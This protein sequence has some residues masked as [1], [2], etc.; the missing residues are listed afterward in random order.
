MKKFLVI[1]FI[2][3]FFNCGNL[4]RDNPLDPKNPDSSVNRAILVELFVNDSTG[5]EFCNY[6]LD[7]IER[8]SQRE[9]NLYVLEYHLTNRTNNWNDLY[10]LD[11]FNQR[12]YEYVPTSSQRGIPDA[13]FN[14][15]VKRIQGASKE[16]IDRRYAEVAEELMGQ[17][18]YFSIAA[19]KNISN[20]IITLNVVV[21]RYGSLTENNIDLNVVLYENL[22]SPRH[23]FVVRKIF[24]KQ[25]IH[26]ISPGEAKSFNFYS[27]LP[28]VE[29]V[30]NLFALVFLQDRKRSTKEVYQVAE[31]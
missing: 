28:Q 2:L 13:L 24:Q 8:L 27:Q 21:A 25:T 14:G 23:Y 6:A 4:D 26:S 9:E 1:L 30:A 29:N 18:G 20:N 7:A 16:Q 15:M 19:K 12:Y 10:A 17:R 5:F 22:S 31:F 11:E 3:L